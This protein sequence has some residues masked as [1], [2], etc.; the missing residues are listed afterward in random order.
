GQA[1]ARRRWKQMSTG[2]NFIEQSCAIITKLNKARIVHVPNINVLDNHSSVGVEGASVIANDIKTKL[3]THKIYVLGLATGST[4]DPLYAE[5]VRMHRE[6][7]LDFSSVVCVNLDNYVGLP[8]TDRNHYGYQL[9]QRFLNHINC[10]EENIHLVSSSPDFSHAA[11]EALIKRLGG[12]DLQIVGVGGEGHLAFNEQGSDENSETREVE[13]SERTKIDNGKYFNQID[14]NTEKMEVIPSTAHTR[15]IKPILEA[16]KILLLVNGYAKAQVMRAFFEKG[17]VQALPVRALHQH[18]SVTIFADKAALALFDA[19]MLQ[20]HTHLNEAERHAIMLANQPYTVSLTT[21]GVAKELWLPPRFDFYDPTMMKE[22]E[23]FDHTNRAHLRWLSTCLEKTTQLGVGAHPDDVEI[24]AGPDMLAAK[25]TWLTLVVTDG[26][27]TSNTLNGDYAKYS[28]EA[29]TNMRQAEQ[30]KA[31]KRANVPLIICK[32]PTAAIAGDM[33]TE[34]L[35]DAKKTMSSLVQAMPNLTTVIG[36]QPSDVHDTHIRVLALQVH[37]LR[38]LSDMQLKGITVLGREVWG[39][40]LAIEARLRKKLVMTEAELD[41][42]AEL[43]AVYES[44]IAGQG[45]DYSLTT[46]ERARGNA[47]YQTHPHGANPPV[48]LLLALDLTDLVYDKKLCVSQFEAR[49]LRELEKQTQSRTQRIY[50]NELK[51][52]PNKTNTSS[53]L[54]L[55]ATLG[56]GLGLVG[57]LITKDYR[58]GVLS[59]ISLVAVSTHVLPNRLGFFVPQAIHDS[60]VNIDSI[61]GMWDSI[62][63][64]NSFST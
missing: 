57:S 60:G 42:W 9:R 24:M 11:Y 45:R 5:L 52:E 36:H 49:L 21:E 16:D 10:K 44:Q 1:A 15:G 29:L 27:A 3:K 46:I 47:G 20:L 33:G 26:A 53:G 41:E 22:D 4:T 19:R 30:R 43:I 31:A 34:T 51:V 58:F 37:A 18:P 8:E 50:R 62:T 28:P 17:T 38:T 2:P 40:M 14:P 12:V 6:E 59:L 7:N 64:D 13:L 56:F 39:L 23:T 32:F 48:G 55:P 35:D 25:D 61:R 63:G 54:I